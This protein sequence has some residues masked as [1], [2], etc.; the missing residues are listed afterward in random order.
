MRCPRVVCGCQ[1]QV[2]FLIDTSAASDQSDFGAG[3]WSE[4]DARAR[5]RDRCGDRRARGRPS[6]GRCWRGDT[7]RRGSGASRREN[8]HRDGGRP[9]HRGR[10]H[11]LHHAMGVRGAVRRVRGALERTGCPR[12]G[13]SS[14]PPRLE[15][16]RAARPLR[17]HRGLGRSDRRLRGSAGGG[18]LPALLCPVGRSLPDAGRRVHPR[19]ADEPGGLGQAGRALGPRRPLADPAL[20]DPMVGPGHVLPRST[21]PAALRPLRHLL[22][23]LSVHRAGDADAGRPCRA[24]GGLDGRGRS[25][26]AGAGGGRSG[27]RAR[28]GVPLRCTGGADPRRAR[29]RRRCASGRWRTDRGRPRRVQRRL[30]RPGSRSPRAGSRRRR[31]A[32]DPRGPLPLGRDPLRDGD[33]AGLP[34]RPPHG[35]LLPRLPRGVRRDPAGAPPADGPHGLHL[36]PGPDRGAARAR[37][38]RAPPDAGQ[39]PGGRPGTPALT[40]G[41]RHMREEPL[42]PAGGLRL[43]AGS[44][45]AGGH[46]DAPGLRHPVPR[47]GGRALRPGGPGLGDDL[48]ARRSAH[49]GA[50][51]LPGGRLGASRPGRADGGAV[52]RLAAAAILDDRASTARS[53]GA[54]TRGGTSM[55]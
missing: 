31:R 10:S 49:E 53:R 16:R 44:G 55:R 25:Q 21:A 41:D 40:A 11:R 9:Q 38:A 48:Q 27:G 50:G 36:R 45:R 20:R 3:A 32:P 52:G 54:A 18:R 51:P 47:D 43:V 4:R 22:R 15:P 33:D 30:C 12:A 46:D 7:R 34:A 19:G 42:P 2:S 29:T 5:R 1:Q 13:Q 24:G 39:R 28:R 17:R 8:A 23:R 6:A 26:R 37:W 14:G 35:V